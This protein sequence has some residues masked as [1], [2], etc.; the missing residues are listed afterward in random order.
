[1]NDRMTELFIKVNILS[2]GHSILRSLPQ[3]PH[4]EVPTWLFGCGEGFVHTGMKVLTDGRLYRIV[5]LDADE[6]A[7]VYLHFVQIRFPVSVCRRWYVV[8][9][10]HN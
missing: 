2:F 1:M 3:P 8:F 5:V 7:L 9:Y 6:C 10:L 4:S